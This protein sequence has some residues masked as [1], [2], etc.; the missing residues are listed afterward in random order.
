R[1]SH[2]RGGLLGASDA[3]SGAGSLPPLSGSIGVRFSPTCS[4]T[5]DPAGFPWPA[6]FLFAQLGQPVA[7]T[8][9][10]VQARLGAAGL[11]LPAVFEADPRR[12]AHQDGFGAATALQAEQGAAVPDQVELDVAAAPVQLELAL[13]LAV[14]HVLAPPDDGQVGV[15]VALADGAG[16]G[17]ARLEAAGLQVVVEQAA[18]AARLV[19]VLEEEVA[20]APGLV[21]GVALRAEGRAQVARHPVPVQHVLVEGVE[22]RQVE[23]AAEPPHRLASLGPGLEEA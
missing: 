22:G 14:G 19:A 2:V 21:F 3:T 6:G 9:V 4:P 16:V 23:T 1:T 15:Q 5:P 17:E 8:Q 20:V 7:R 11:G 10:V 18:D 13:A 12:Q